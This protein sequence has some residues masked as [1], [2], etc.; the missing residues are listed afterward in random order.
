M[1]LFFLGDGGGGSSG[2][3]G[4]SAGGGGGGG[5]NPSLLKLLTGGGGGAAGGG[6]MKA[7][8]GSCRSLNCLGALPISAPAPVAP[9]TPFAALMQSTLNAMGTKNAASFMNG[10]AQGMSKATNEYLSQ[11][12]S[13]GGD[14]IG[15]G[16][17]SAIGASGPARGGG[18]KRSDLKCKRDKVFQIERSDLEKLLQQA[19]TRDKTSASTP[20]TSVKTS[21]KPNKQT[22]TS[23]KSRQQ[24]GPIF[25]MEKLTSEQSGK[26]LKKLEKDAKGKLKEKQGSLQQNVLNTILA[27][28]AQSIKFGNGLKPSKID[29]LFYTNSVI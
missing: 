1:T 16:P 20:S 9:S 10:L 4:G 27:S 24:I 29:I 6:L 23:A 14:I 2:G 3:G 13:G 17:T 26:K 22:S 28:K 19:Q 18:C 15:G 7:L 21:K 11:I 12:K 25:G 8:T 5:V